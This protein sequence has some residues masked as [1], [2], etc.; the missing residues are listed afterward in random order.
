M[1]TRNLEFLFRPKSI[2]VIGASDR[3]GSV[4][5][6]VMRNIVAGGFTGHTYAVNPAHA[7]VAGQ[8]AYASVEDLPQTPDLAV[9]ATP[10]AKVPALISSL[11]ARGTRAAVVLSG[12]LDKSIRKA[13]CDA[14][15]PHL[16][17]ILGP[18]CVGLLALG[19]GL[20][21][22]F[23]HTSALKGNLAFV[24]Q[25]GGLTTAVLDWAKSRGIGFSHFITP[26]RKYD[27]HRESSGIPDVLAVEETLDHIGL[28]LA[29]AQV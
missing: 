6:T 7:N 22:S 10:A 25:S 4:G 8:L 23:A 26:L 5:A 27:L 17:R 18:N 12:G 9:I 15:R 11:G 28:P 24:S 2:A 21:A 3:A 20:N 14:A 13:M 1:S 29:T 16:L 19:I